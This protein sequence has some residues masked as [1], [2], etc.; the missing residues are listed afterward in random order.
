MAIQARYGQQS[1]SL[2]GNQG[3]IN[4][5]FRERHLVGDNTPVSGAP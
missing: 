2:L 1:E 5:Q 4:L 3:G